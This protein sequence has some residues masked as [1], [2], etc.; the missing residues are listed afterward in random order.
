M[1]SVFMPIDSTDVVAARKITMLWFGVSAPT[2]CWGAVISPTNDKDPG[3]FGAPRAFGARCPMLLCSG[4]APERG[5]WA[6]TCSV[7]QAVVGQQRITKESGGGRGDQRWD[8]I[9]IL[10]A[11]DRIQQDTYRGGPIGSMDGFYLMEQMRG[12]ADPQL[13][14]GLVQELHIPRDRGLQT[15]KVRPDPR[16][17]LAEADPSRYLQTLSDFALPWRGTGREAG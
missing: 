2:R 6:G 14:R 17:N 12:R 11:I 4:D 7:Q 10:Q 13:T 5:D 3:S 1:R 15:F 16:P 9:E 8:N